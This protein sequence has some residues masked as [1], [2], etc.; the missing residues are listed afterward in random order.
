MERRL[1][2]W[3]EIHNWTAVIFEGLRVGTGVTGLKHVCRL[4]R[5]NIHLSRP[6]EGTTST[7]SVRQHPQQFFFRDDT[8][9]VPMTPRRG[10]P[11]GWNR[12]DQRTL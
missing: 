1:G 12:C 6:S 8:V 9:P 11:V 7:L 10:R 5:R 4:E 2:E 3:G